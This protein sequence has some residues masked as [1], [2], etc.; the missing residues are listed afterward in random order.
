MYVCMYTARGQRLRG[1]RRLYL[2][3]RAARRAAAAAAGVI[4]AVAQS[5]SVGSLCGG[6]FVGT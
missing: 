2:A 5:L 4:S 6:E 1:D 3:R